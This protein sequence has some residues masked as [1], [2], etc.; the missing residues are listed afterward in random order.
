MNTQLDLADEAKKLAE[1]AGEKFPVIGKNGESKEIPKEELDKAKR[2]QKLTSVLRMY[3]DADRL[4][5]MF[6]W[7]MIPE[8]QY[9][10][11]SIAVLDQFVK[12]L[13]DLTENVR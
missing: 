9:I 7:R 12:E 11:E 13:K 1:Q 2:A 5:K 6:H 4:F 3:L 10:E 8:E